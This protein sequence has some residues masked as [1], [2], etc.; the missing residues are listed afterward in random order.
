MRTHE[1]KT[2]PEPFDALIRGAKTFELRQDDR[3]FAVG[4]TLVLREWV[5][6]PSYLVD[7]GRYTGRVHRARVT[8]LLHGGRFGLP[9]GLCV[10]SLS[11][12][13]EGKR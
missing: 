12:E 13:P 4:D 2:W 9:E 3:G 11:P 5:P 1:L 6:D 7:R 8:Y 10:M